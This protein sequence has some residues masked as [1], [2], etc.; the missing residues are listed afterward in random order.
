MGE[1]VRLEL[2][3]GADG[4]AAVALRLLPPA[5]GAGERWGEL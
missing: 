2:S 3:V 1:R 5:G 4:A